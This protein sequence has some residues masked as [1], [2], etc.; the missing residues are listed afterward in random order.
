LFSA[1]GSSGSKSGTPVAPETAQS[2]TAA[3]QNNTGDQSGQETTGSIPQDTAASEPSASGKDENPD[4]AG[5]QLLQSASIDLDNDGL[6]EQVK[7]V[8]VTI[9]GDSENPDRLKGML[10]I[11]SGA[12]EDKEA[13][14]VFWWE[15]PAGTSGVLN[16]MQ[17]EDLDGDGARDIFIIIPDNGASFAYSNYYLYS[18]KKDVSY[19]FMN[20]SEMTDFIDSFRFT[21]QNGNKLSLV[22][23]K[24]HFSADFTIEGENGG[25]PSEEV[26]DDYVLRAWIEPVSVDIGEDSRM[27]LAKGS[28]GAWEIKVPLPVFGLA[29]VD[30]IG[31]IDL[32]FSVDSTFN[33]VLK[34]F[35]VLDFKGSE[36]TK[37]GSCTVQ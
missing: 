27:A 5:E 29:T 14:Q 24:Y 7:A 36:K 31:E 11:R 2:G 3:E 15:K 22:N 17:F 28:G 13:R 23:D 37:V 12:S 33:P 25:P 16:G 8:Q 9:K 35:D 26:M 32:Y 19:S 4:G 1:C 34:H 6:N 18:Y 21:H 20:N 10:V 30:M